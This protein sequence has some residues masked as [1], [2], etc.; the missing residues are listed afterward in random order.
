MQAAPALIRRHLVAVF[1]ASLAA[2]LASAQSRDTLETLVSVAGDEVTFKWSKKHPWDAALVAQGVSLYAEYRTARGPGL[3]CLQTRG[4]AAGARVPGAGAGG[5]CFAGNPVL[6]SEDRTI[7]FQLPEALT[8]E[9]LGPVCLQ[10]RLPDQ[11]LLPI[12]RANKLGEDTARFQVEEW[13]RNA[14]GRA[15]LATLES[16]RTALRNAIATQSAEITEQAQANQAKGWTSGDACAA[17]TGGTVEIEASGR[18]IAQP[19]EQD[20]IAR[21]VCVLRLDRD[22]K[23][24]L[25]IASPPRYLPDIAGRVDD[26]MR[27]RWLAIRGPQYTQYLDDWERYGPTAE[28]YQRTHRIPHFGMY[29]DRLAIQSLAAR[30]FQRVLVATREKREADPADVLGVIGATIEAYDRCVR[31]GKR[32]LD[33]NYREAAALESTVK[34]LP[35]RLRQQAVQACQGGIDRLAGMRSRLTA[36]EREALGVEREIALIVISP[37]QKKSRALNAAVCTP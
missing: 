6:R 34:T 14:T 4:A 32:Q 35:E 22:G 25:S 33:L 10:L 23:E 9:P 12:R 29:D 24:G 11:R 17:L 1:V 5:N 36:F 31:D 30:A 13:S 2:A 20:A 3:E 27:D 37:L 19:Q 26:Q 7:R 8:A 21:Q 16:R 18:P 15:R 28:V